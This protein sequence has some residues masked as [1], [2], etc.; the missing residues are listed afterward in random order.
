MTPSG[1]LIVRNADVLVTMDIQRREIR[2]GV[3]CAQGSTI[4]AVGPSCELPQSADRV[5]DLAGHA[6]VAGVVN[7][8]HHMF[9]SLV[10]G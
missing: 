5:L 10:A 4:T 3:L 6:V 9:Q 8:H 2:G 7:T 1:T